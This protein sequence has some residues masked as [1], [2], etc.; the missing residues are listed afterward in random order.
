MNEG[1]E[2]FHNRKITKN[3]TKL[4][5]YPPNRPD[6]PKI[7]HHNYQVLTD[8]GAKPDDSSKGRQLYRDILDDV[9]ETL[10]RHK[11]VF[12]N[13]ES[14][15]VYTNVVTFAITSYAVLEEFNS[16]ED[17]FI[18]SGNPTIQWQKFQSHNKFRNN[19]EHN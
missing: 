4:R 13:A 8:A 2:Y 5:E 12:R 7:H 9:T 14:L 1:F 16:K 10:H 17:R 19:F 11:Y 6:I 3:P 18:L 15:A